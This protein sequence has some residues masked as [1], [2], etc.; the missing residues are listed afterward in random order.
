MSTA[1][2]NPPP[3]SAATGAPSPFPGKTARAVAVLVAVLLGWHLWRNR[4]EGLSPGIF[5][6]AA[7]LHLPHPPRPATSTPRS[8]SRPASDAAAESTAR[9][10]G[11]P[12]SE[13]LL[14]DS[15]ALDPFFAALR[16]LE[17]GGGGA[18]DVVSILHYGDS[19]T[20]ADLIT[21]DVRAM[22]Q[23][24]F[25]DAGHG[26]NLVGKPW[27]WYGH[28][29]VEIS[30]HGWRSLTGVGSM[31]QGVYGLGGATLVGG[32]DARSRFDLKD[33]GTTTSAELQYLS[34]PNGGS[35]TISANGTQVLT[36]PT[37]GETD[38]P[39]ARRVRLPEG[40]R[41]IE[42]SVAGQVK[43]LGLD[44]RTG[45][46]GVLY[47]SL[48]LNGASTTVISRAFAP[49]PWAAEL[50][51]AAPALVIL[52]YGTNESGFPA[53][54]H[55]QYEGELRLAITKLRA[56]L[57]DVPILI[58]SPMDRAQR[59]G[60]NDLRT[61]TAIPEIVAIQRRVAADTHCAF[62]DTYNAMGGDGTMARW[63]AAR[64]RLVSA[65]FIH[66]TPQ[67]ALL[68]AR[69]LVENLDLGYDRWRRMHGIAASEPVTARESTPGGAPAAGAQSATG[70]ET[71]R[72][73]ND[74]Q[75]SSPGSQGPELL[76]SPRPASTSQP[77]RARPGKPSAA[78]PEVTHE[79][80]ASEVQSPPAP[81]PAP[82]QGPDASKP[83]EP[84]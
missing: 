25:G 58:M 37:E 75:P 15:R 23:A 19:P 63:F 33:G 11:P 76:T 66:P 28:R 83:A 29:G 47:D 18:A 22:L 26:F 46:S 64:P 34:E 70:A 12:I 10:V 38:V 43:L 57:P 32:G 82:D 54:V 5:R 13:F 77:E 1:T 81:A 68:V 62:F 51:Q 84:Q 80:G 60:L 71:Q 9:K 49:G 59:A 73:V 50:R 56:A 44:L 31:R 61:M 53:F 79:N 14:D 16:R 27:A 3:A 41:S 40:T 42:L 7:S 74:R 8:T 35:V 2:S 20:T 78:V 24:R 67:G 4:A 69:L 55:K 21:G 17:R 65:D 52:N 39:V 30:D 36:I 48:G 45:R 72:R 6:E